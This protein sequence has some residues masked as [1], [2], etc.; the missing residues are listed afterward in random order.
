[1]SADRMLSSHSL[2]SFNTFCIEVTGV[3]STLTQL[4]EEREKEKESERK[5]ER[6]EKR[7]EREREREKRVFLVHE[8]KC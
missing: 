6:E 3:S 8:P 7:R 2:V 1:M 4:E 5:R